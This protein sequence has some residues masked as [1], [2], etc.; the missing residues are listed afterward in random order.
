[1][2]NFTNGYRPR[3]S[4]DSGSG[5]TAIPNYARPVG[6][7][8]P[9]RSVI[10][11]FGQGAGM[12]PPPTVAPPIV[13]P[14][15]G[16][17]YGPPGQPAPPI[18]QPSPIGQPVPGGGGQGP[19]GQPSYPTIIQPGPRYG[20]PQG[21]GDSRSISPPITPSPF[22]GAPGYGTIRAQR[23]TAMPPPGHEMTDWNR[24]GSPGKALGDF[25]GAIGAA[26]GD[27]QAGAGAG[28]PMAPPST[29]PPTP[30]PAPRVPPSAPPQDMRHPNVDQD[31]N[32][33]A[34]AKRKGTST[35]N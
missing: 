4:G 23:G 2:G 28:A 17:G 8:G 16:A 13:Q 26:A 14:G 33:I 15:R 10:G 18:V 19:P 35:R 6:P 31:G 29:S 3:S 21:W 22:S 1:M 5:P 20:P 7:V 25:T 24:N 30:S 32:E 9:P 12:G 11:A 34:P 27:G